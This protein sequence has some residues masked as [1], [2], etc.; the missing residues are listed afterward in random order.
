MNSSFKSIESL[1]ITPK[2]VN[3]DCNIN[4]LDNNIK[5]YFGENIPV[6]VNNTFDPIN[7]DKT[8]N[9]EYKRL[10]FNSVKK[11]FYSNYISGSFLTGSRYYNYEQSTLFSGS[12]N[13][14]VRDL[15]DIP[16]ISFSN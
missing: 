10:I 16:G 3:K 15:K 5:L 7:D 14:T 13:T 4:Y 8:T 12:F 11:L 1:Y 2:V 9:D 6:N